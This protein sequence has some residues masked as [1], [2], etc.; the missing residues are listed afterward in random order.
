[1]RQLA[2]AGPAG[3]DFAEQDIKRL[4]PSAD[5]DG[6]IIGVLAAHLGSY[7]ALL[8]SPE[9]VAWMRGRIGRGCIAHNAVKNHVFHGFSRM[10]SSVKSV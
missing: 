2:R 4:V 3:G 6:G 7:L 10:R 9:K 1:M 8:P 5:C